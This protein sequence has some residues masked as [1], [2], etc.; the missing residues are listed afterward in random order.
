MND[1]SL[2]AKELLVNYCNKTASKDEE[3][4]VEYSYNRDQIEA[5]LKTKGSFIEETFCFSKLNMHTKCFFLNIL[6]FI[7]NV[8]CLSL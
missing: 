7:L 6:I 8:T 1:S 5:V 2:Q 4:I 3:E